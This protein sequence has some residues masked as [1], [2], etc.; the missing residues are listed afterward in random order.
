VR[1]ND[2]PGGIILSENLTAA[3]KPGDI[4]I[5][6]AEEDE[7]VAGK[8]GKGKKQA[9]TPNIS[10]PED[11]CPDTNKIEDCGHPHPVLKHSGCGGAAEP[12]YEPARV[13]RA[14]RD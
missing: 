6:G 12:R 8:K 1:L 13:P 7:Y 3:P 4:V 14:G 2:E 9:P 5:D 11:R 10:T